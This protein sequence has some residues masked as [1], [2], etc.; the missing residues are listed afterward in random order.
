M[1]K[2]IKIPMRF[3]RDMA[4]SAVI[5][6]SDESVGRKVDQ[7]FAFD[8]REIPTRSR[9]MIA[10]KACTLVGGGL[11]SKQLMT[12]RCSNATSNLYSLFGRHGLAK[13]DKLPILARFQVP[14]GNSEYFWVCKFADRGSLAFFVGAEAQVAQVGVDISSYVVKAEAD[15]SPVV[16]TSHI[17]F[18]TM[19][20][21]AAQKLNCGASDLAEIYVEV[22]NTR[23]SQHCAGYGVEV[24]DARFNEA[25]KLRGRNIAKP[26]KGDPVSEDVIQLPFG[27]S[28]NLKDST[29]EC[30]SDFFAP[31]A[32]RDS[33]EED[34]LHARDGEES[35]LVDSGSSD[36]TEAVPPGETWAEFEAGIAQAQELGLQA[37]R[38]LGRSGILDGWEMAFKGIICY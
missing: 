5:A 15:G 31:A 20:N 36:G 24:V 37:R 7:A 11:C 27:F 17:I 30:A 3:H 16:N 1:Q 38:A 9:R 25:L 23:R 32:Q 4:A 12:V 34:V 6:G 33:D 28:V 29:S 13:N 21:M 2:F 8:D 14:G 26:G 19:L 18:S 10:Y 22:F 35:D